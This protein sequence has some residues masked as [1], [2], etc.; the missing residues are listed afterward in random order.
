MIDDCPACAEVRRSGGWSHS[1]RPDCRA[2]T[3]RYI[4][5]GPHFFASLRD[6]KLTAKYIEQ[7]QP[8]G[9]IAAVHAEVKSVAKALHTGAVAA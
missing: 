1:T 6:G 7:L 8:L 3:L 4:A 5:R 2:C 9:D